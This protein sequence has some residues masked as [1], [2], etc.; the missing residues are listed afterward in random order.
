MKLVAGTFCRGISFPF[1]G[2]DVQ[3]HWLLQTAVL[4]LALQ[5]LHDLHQSLDIVSVN[6]THVVESKL[7]E[8]RTL[9]SR[10]TATKRSRLHEVPRVLVNLSSRGRERPR[11][12]L[13]KVLRHLPHVLEVVR[14]FELRDIVLQTQPFCFRFC[15]CERLR[16]RANRLRDAVIEGWKGDLSVVIQNHHHLRFQASGVVHCFPCHAT[17]NGAVTDDSDAVARSALEFASSLISQCCADGG[18]GMSSAKCV[19][20]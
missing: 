6:G 15:S 11:Q 19:V 10:A 2:L 18:G 1:D 8:Q 14:C 4:V 5:V 20:L 12:R 17:S 13:R 16:Q 3:E 7:L 9:G